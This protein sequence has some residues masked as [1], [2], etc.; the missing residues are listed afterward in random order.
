MIQ[1]LSE[2]TDSA[3]RERV[4]STAQSK[5][6]AE[7][8]KLLQSDLSYN[9]KLPTLKKEIVKI[10]IEQNVNS[11]FETNLVQMKQ[12]QAVKSERSKKR[13][14]IDNVDQM[15]RELIQGSNEPKRKAVPAFLQK[16]E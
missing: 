10:F 1:K 14:D 11:Q 7:L 13:E 16:T 5:T 12:N 3:F 8:T 6:I 15:Q 9:K 4:K 2:E